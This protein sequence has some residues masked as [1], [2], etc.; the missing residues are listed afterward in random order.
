LIFLLVLA[1]AKMIFFR[2][3]RID[4]IGP[5]LERQ[6]MIRLLGLEK[7]AVY[8]ALIFINLV[9]IHLQTSLILVSHR[10][11]RGINRFYF[12]MLIGVL[13][14]LIPYYYGRGRMLL[15]DRRIVSSREKGGDLRPSG[16][17]DSSG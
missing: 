10:L 14:I 2:G 17:I 15:R 11:G 16:H 7:E 12:L 5:D 9:F 1:V 6:T 4:P 8:L 3:S 13:A